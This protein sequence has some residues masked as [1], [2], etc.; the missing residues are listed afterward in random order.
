V[1]H[2]EHFS[3]TRATLVNDLDLSDLFPRAILEN[4]SAVG[5]HGVEGVSLCVCG[6]SGAG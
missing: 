2:N 1:V 3:G 5:R 6:D 4:G